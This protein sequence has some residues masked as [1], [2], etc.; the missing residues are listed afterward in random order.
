M[1]RSICL[2]VLASFCFFSFGQ[3]I[4]LSFHHLT[5][6]Q[7][8]SNDTN[9]YVYKDSRGF[10]WVSSVDGL[11]RFDGHSVKVYRPDINSEH[12]I[13]GNIVSSNFYEDE[14]ANIWFTTYG[15]INCY[16][17]AFDHFISF[18]LKNVEGFTLTED[19]RAFHLDEDNGLW[20]RTGLR[21]G[22][23]LHLFD[24]NTQS[25]KIIGAIDGRRNYLL[26]DERKT[27]HVIST[28]FEERPGLEIKQVENGK[29]VNVQKYFKGQAGLPEMFLYNIFTEE[30]DNIYLGSVDGLVQFSAITGKYDIYNSFEGNHL[31]RVWSVA[32]LSDAQLLVSSQLQGLLIFDE[33]RSGFVQSYRA[34]RDRAY[35]LS[36]DAISEVYID[37]SSCIWVSIWGQG[38]DYA[39]LDKNRF[40]LVNL[41]VNGAE[42]NDITSMVPDKAGRIWIADWQKGITVMNMDKSVHSKMNPLKILNYNNRY[43]LEHIQFDNSGRL[44]GIVRNNESR[45][46]QLI[47][48]DAQSAKWKRSIAS[49]LDMTSLKE[50]ANGRVLVTTKTGVLELVDQKKLIPCLDFDDYRIFPFYKMFEDKLGRLYLSAN[51]DRILVYEDDGLGSLK[52]L[53]NINKTGQVNSF[54]EPSQDSLLW[55]ASGSGLLKINKY[56]F[57]YEL[58]SK[59]RDDIAIESMFAIAG[60]NDNNLWVKNQMGIIQYKTEEKLSSYYNEVDGTQKVVN[61]DVAHV[62]DDLGNIW[63]AGPRGITYFSPDSIQ[64]YPISPQPQIIDIKVNTAPITLDTFIGE[65]QRIDLRYDDNTIA[66]KFVPNAYSDPARSRFRYRVLGYDPIWVTG[67]AQGIA[68]M[69]NVPWGEYEFQVQATNSDGIWSPSKTLTICIFP[70]WWATWWAFLLYIIGAYVL[71]RGYFA[72]RS[73]ALIT[74]NAQLEKTVDERTAALSKSLSKLQETQ[75][76]LLHSEKMAALGEVTAGVAHE[77]RNP[78]NFVNN[79]SD[80]SSDLLDEMIEE[81]DK[82]DLDEVKAIVADV[83]KNLGRIA[84]HGNRA[85]GIV[86]SMLEHSQ[87][88]AGEITS[89][90]INAL[91]QANLRRTYTLIKNQERYF[92]TVI[93]TNLNDTIGR[94]SVIP[95]DIG[96]VIYNVLSNALYA[97]YAKKKTADETYQPTVQVS[98]Y[99]DN[100]TISISIKDNGI[101]MASDVTPKIFQ[102]FF[103]TKPSGEGTG[104]GLSLSFDI[105][106][107]HG[108]RIIVESEEEVGSTFI[109]QLPNNSKK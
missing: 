61:N 67:E 11:N 38:V 18:Q 102:P 52:L 2:L 90:D 16:V 101:G 77:I 72:Y 41:P 94:I 73:R 57:D 85:D 100:E 55:V 98:T 31:G 30:L 42:D 97:T 71:I 109:I 74:Q 88:S 24:I 108:G 60:G 89:T 83:Q 58:L 44:W 15:S 104:L 65:S 75:D 91:V 6:A 53:Q 12:S 47:Y 63:F 76:Q 45:S 80:V 21:E 46:S 105:V 70:P 68:R 84:H 43:S 95:Q 93:E 78:L 39:C 66:L 22:G 87:A 62:Q 4:A 79:F 14:D 96:R 48:K 56:T 92:D 59:D 3:E 28:M 107:S 25:D 69:V 51:Y 82:G 1:K 36:D 5:S 13:E 26:K 9:S 35:S 37:R 23:L 49:S 19:Y 40:E 86:R 17:R 8:L 81:M 33:E 27:A 106:R 32:R 50:L 54:Y 103:T 10:V 29:I 99:K 64:V 34:N 20:V 7:G